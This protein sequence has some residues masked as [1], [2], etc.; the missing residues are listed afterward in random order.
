MFRTIRA[1]FVVGFFLIFCL[2]FLVLN[3][4]LK[5]VIRTSNQ[6]IITSDLIGLKNNSNVYVRQAF[7]DQSLH[8]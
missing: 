5:E 8:E 3:G 4:T 6:K 2:S 1:K 7:L